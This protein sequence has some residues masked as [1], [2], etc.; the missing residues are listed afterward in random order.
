MAPFHLQPRHKM[1]S[2]A[3]VHLQSRY[4]SASMASGNNRGQKAPPFGLAPICLVYKT[5]V[6]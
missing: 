6:E 2:M 5:E 4:K 3:P 1:T